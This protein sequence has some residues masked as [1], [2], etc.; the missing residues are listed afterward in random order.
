MKSI[1]IILIILL[2]LI[3]IF[4]RFIISSIILLR[5]VLFPI[6]L[7]INLKIGA[8]LILIDKAKLILYLFYPLMILLDPEGGDNLYSGNSIT[9]Y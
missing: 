3:I 1:F 8:L 9:I 5:L 4:F 2:Y 7:P 6:L